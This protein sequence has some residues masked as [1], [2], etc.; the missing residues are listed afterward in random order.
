MMHSKLLKNTNNNV[1]SSI[2]RDSPSKMTTGGARKTIGTT[3]APPISK[4][5]N[6]TSLVQ[7]DDIDSKGL[8]SFKN[9]KI[10]KTLKQTNS[11]GSDV[12]KMVSPRETN[13]TV[14]S[15]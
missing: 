9:A 10:Y 14:I 5:I 15:A 11:K 13:M 3:A 4:Q 7:K 2:S 6:N 12:R 1:I 8:N